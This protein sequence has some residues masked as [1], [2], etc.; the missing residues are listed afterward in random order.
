MWGCMRRKDNIVLGLG[1][2][3][4]S[5]RHI[6]WKFETQPQSVRLDWEVCRAWDLSINPLSVALNLPT[7][8]RIHFILG[9]MV[10]F[11]PSTVLLGGGVKLG[12]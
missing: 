7:P 10:L 12:S 1:L 2:R 11:L 3:A 6:F 8:R 9:K 4:E 5:P